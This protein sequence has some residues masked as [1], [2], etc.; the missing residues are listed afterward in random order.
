MALAYTTVSRDR[1]IEQ[2]LALQALNHRHSVD[3]ATAISDGFTSVRH[4]PAVL[5]AMNHEYPSVIAKSGD[6]LA[7]YCLMMAQ[8]FR[9]QIP[10]LQPMF[11]MLDSLSWRGEALADNPR[12]FVMGQV[13]VAREF[14]GQ[15]VFDGMYHTLRDVYRDRFDF[16]V[17][18]IS[19]R[20]AR[21]L[22]AHRRVGF[23]TLHV[24]EDAQA[25]DVWEVVVWD[26]R[27]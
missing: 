11:A 7:G 22:R 15:G 18:E 20:N 3:A 27:E 23:E 12:W 5:T 10:I 14:R 16:S 17:T 1:E 13:C 6:D 21:S 2:I 8:R 4:D 25:D 9:D 19:Q 24:Y 26:W